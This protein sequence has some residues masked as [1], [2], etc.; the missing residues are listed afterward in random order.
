MASCCGQHILTPA[1]VPSRYHR[2]PCG[3]GC[4]AEAAAGTTVCVAIRM[5]RVVPICRGAAGVS[6][7]RAPMGLPMQQQQQARGGGGTGGGESEQR[8]AVLRRNIRGGRQRR[9]AV[10][11]AAAKHSQARQR[12]GQ[13]QR[14]HRDPARPSVPAHVPKPCGTRNLPRADDQTPQAVHVQTA[15]D[16]HTSA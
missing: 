4:L 15:L 1:A 12:P 13:R 6:H 8:E 11:A 9:Q 16:A 5:R 7:A 2:L 10:G 14:P 3:I